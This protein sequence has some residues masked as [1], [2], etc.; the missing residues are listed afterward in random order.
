MKLKSKV[1]MLSM[2][3]LLSMSLMV[4]CSSEGQN[5]ETLSSKENKKDE[6]VLVS[7]IEFV[8]SKI[9]E[10]DSIGNRYFKTF[11]K[12][13]SDKTIT[14]VS[15]EFELD[16]GEVTYLSTYDTLKPGDT[17]SIVECLASTT[18]NIDDMKAK[19]VS[20]VAISG[21]KQLFIDYDVKLEKYDVFEGEIE[22]QVE[23]PVLVK[24]IEVINPT[25]LEPDSIG[26]RYLTTNF[27]N[28]SKLPI[29]SISIELE[30]DNGEVT[31]LSSYD[32]L[33]PGDKSS[34]IE[35]SGPTTGNLKDVKAKRV[36]IVALNNAKKE[37]YIDYDIKLNKYEVMVSND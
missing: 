30:L 28:N 19:N 3:L 33:L 34:N 35:C 25:V 27:K 37:I 26:N 22:E 24:D 9:L 12:N 2:S 7:D 31:Y 10:P 21:D 36:S 6:K 15:V 16:N 5:G 1:I 20:I 32:T 11:F 14:S 8:D 4:G 18:G 13:N 23:S 17:S 29:T